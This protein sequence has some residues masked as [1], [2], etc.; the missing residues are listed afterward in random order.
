MP[1]GDFKGWEITTLPTWFMTWLFRQTYVRP[2][3]RQPVARELRKR[4][5]AI[6]KFSHRQATEL[7]VGTD[8]AGTGETPLTF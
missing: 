2:N 6:E 4:L 1:F 5:D 8:A 3:L 7:G